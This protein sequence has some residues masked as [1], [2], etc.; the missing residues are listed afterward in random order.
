MD[1]RTPVGPG[2]SREV[3]EPRCVLW[4]AGAPVSA[5]GRRNATRGE[6]AP[7]RAMGPPGAALTWRGA[8]RFAIGNRGSLD[9]AI[10]AQNARQF[11]FR[12]PLLDFKNGSLA[13]KGLLRCTRSPSFPVAPWC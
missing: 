4:A 1:V 2:E 13:S 6:R 3:S 11:F 8:L 12:L 5:V 7:V 9:C 10:R